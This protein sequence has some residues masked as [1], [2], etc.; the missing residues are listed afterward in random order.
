MIDCV[1]T[2]QAL[3]EHEKGLSKKACMLVVA[4][5]NK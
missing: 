5:L 1:G 4:K 2:K 3:L